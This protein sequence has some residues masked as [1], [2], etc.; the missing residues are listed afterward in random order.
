MPL[1][2]FVP[3]LLDVDADAL[4][5]CAPLS[6]VA[7]RSRGERADDADAAMLQAL[8]TEAA[9]APLAALG[10][11]LDAGGDW[12][13]RADPVTT[14]VTHE[15]VRIVARVDD[16]ADDEVLALRALLDRHFAGDGLA[17]A[18]PRPDAWFVRSR[19]PHAVAF[20]PLAAA[21]G[22]ALRER[23]P[24]GADAARW[25]RWWTEIQMLLHGQPV[26]AR[27]RAPV[28]ALW[29]SGAGTLPRQ[30]I[31]PL[32]AR[33]TAARAGDVARGLALLAGTQAA[34]LREWCPG[35]A[36]TQV[37]VVDPV[38]AGSLPSFAETMLAPALAALDRGAFDRLV[39]IAKGRDGAARWTIGRARLLDRVLRRSSPFT[40]PPR[41]AT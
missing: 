40:V 19:V 7:A 32:D 4:A 1:V 34:P 33:A 6:R 13:A 24:T 16:L 41:D 26:A 37:V 20:M 15:D 8:G 25:R 30:R 14:L 17:F 36:A 28:D 10:A 31:A 21:I 35:S 5:A 18:A 29:F 39:L 12:I 23:L 2:L 38:D 11:G 22:R 9:V 27:E 3:G